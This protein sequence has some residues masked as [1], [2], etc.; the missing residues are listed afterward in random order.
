LLKLLS[1]PLSIYRYQV[2]RADGLPDV[3][4]TLFADDQMKALSPSSV[5]VY[6]RE[7]L[8]FINWSECDPI[9]TGNRWSLFGPPVEVRNVI[10][11]YL[12]V[13]ARCKVVVRPDM[14]GLKASY[15]NET[16][17]TRINIRVFLTALKRFYDHLIFRH[18]YCH[19]NPL[20]HESAAGMLAALRNTYRRAVREMEGRDP[21]PA[22]SGVDPPSGIRLSQN[23]F[24]CVQKEW[25]PQT[26]D[27]PHFPGLIFR[28]GNNWGWGLREKCIVRT[29]FES[30]ARI[31]E[32]LDLTALDW[33]VSHFLNR[34][35][36][37]NKGSFGERTKH[38]VVSQA[39]AKLYRRYF[40]HEVTGR[41]ACDPE[42]LTL[43]E[44]DKMFA[45]DPSRLQRIPIFL[46][47][48]GTRMTEKLF[49]D[50]YWKPA[51]R[52]AGL[53]AHPH[54]GRHWFVT[55]ALR[56]IEQ[57]SKNAGDR[58]RRKHELIQYMSW[59][60]GEK[61]LKAYEHLRRE[62]EFVTSTLPGIHAAM[63]RRE[64]GSARRQL[65]DSV[66]QVAPTGHSLPYDEEFATLTGCFDEH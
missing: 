3:E 13:A 10:R 22:V 43:N 4:L 30:G 54:Q 23:F 41:R 57:V 32:I 48:R 17:A 35:R 5:P 61:T 27:D 58:E 63:K 38:L 33:A 46:T 9:V 7:I 14:A 25:V 21:M 60:T 34:F 45:S 29:L 20:I 52:A 11:Q 37:R 26:I 51:L 15:V 47:N 18:V 55:N 62:E 53:H 42:Q 66:H 36:A 50:W 24:R 39:T 12:T 31:S 1:T 40:D 6:I 65:P 19:A 59:K 49:R 56:N 64:Q 2:V 8:S 44:I 28:A 16:S